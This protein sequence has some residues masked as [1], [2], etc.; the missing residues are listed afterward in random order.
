MLFLL[1]HIQTEN[2]IKLCNAVPKI[3]YDKG[4]TETKIHKEAINICQLY[5]TIFHK[6][7]SCHQ[8]INL[9]TTFD[10]KM[11]RELGMM[12]VQTK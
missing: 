2:I 5:K 9:S 11:L 6:Y 10:S 1:L 12:C 7:S 8:I 4:F 3:I